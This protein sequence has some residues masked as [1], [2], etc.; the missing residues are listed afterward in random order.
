MDTY[1]DC[2]SEEFVD[3]TP[4]NN[5][6][7]IQEKVRQ[8]DKK[9]YYRVKKKIEKG[10]DITELRLGDGDGSTVLMA[11]SILGY[12]DTVRLVLSIPDVDRHINVKD[13]NGHTALDLAANEDIKKLL[14]DA[15]KGIFPTIARKGS[16]VR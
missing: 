3:D 15:E 7:A 12:T 14:I 16:Q 11:A 5:D 4:T 1:K 6:W 10:A 8:A 13:K 2:N 9:L